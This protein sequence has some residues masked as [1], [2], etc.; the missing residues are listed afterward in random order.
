MGCFG[1]YENSQQVLDEWIKDYNC[2]GCTCLDQKL[3]K[4]Y[5][6]LLVS[7]NQTNEKFIA[8]FIFRKDYYKPLPWCD[9]M[10]IKR[11]PK[12]W[13]S[14]VVPFLRG[15]EKQIYEY[16]Y[17]TLNGPKLDEILKPKKQ[18]II[19]GEPVTYSYKLKRTHVFINDEGRFVKFKGLK[20]EDVEEITG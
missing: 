6:A 10:H 13:I 17:K 1:G 4:S 20:S 3:T 19:W 14:Q 8:Y 7:D 18:Y 12:K 11:I 2:S 5:G 15:G 9:Y 16:T